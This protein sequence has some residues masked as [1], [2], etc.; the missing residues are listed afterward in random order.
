MWPSV[1]CRVHFIFPLK[2]RGLILH[3]CTQSTAYILWQWETKVK[4]VKSSKKKTEIKDVSKQRERGNKQ[5]AS[6]WHILTVKREVT[7]RIT[8]ETNQNL[9][10]GWRKSSDRIFKLRPC[11]TVIALAS[12][13]LQHLH[14]THILLQLD[15]QDL[16]LPAQIDTPSLKSLAALDTMHSFRAFFFPLCQFLICLIHCTLNETTNK[17]TWLQ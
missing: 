15:L 11:L 6:V 3:V 17:T 7:R 12:L 4:V 8:W 14:R 9:S 5:A 10:G 16:I 1:I 13:S 2:Q